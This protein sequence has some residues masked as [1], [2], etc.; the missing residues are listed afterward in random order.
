[1]TQI[2]RDIWG[3]IPDKTMR[4]LEGNPETIEM[5]KRLTN[6]VRNWVHKARSYDGVQWLEIYDTEINN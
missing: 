3:A 2:E 1:M 5:I 6:I 4:K